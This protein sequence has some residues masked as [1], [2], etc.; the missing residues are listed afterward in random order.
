M[1]K[2]EAKVE[3][4]ED[5]GV[6]SYIYVQ[7]DGMKMKIIKSKLPQWLDVGDTIFCNFPE[8]SV[9]I[10]KDCTKQVSVENCLNASLINIRKS[11]PLC[12]L[13]FD[14]KMGKVV[15][16][17]TTDSFDLLDLKSGDNATMLIRG[18]DINI[19]PKIENHQ[20]KTYS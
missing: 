6:V 9:C 10:G 3:H 12:E 19:E 2:I 20:I 18:I 8:A 7:S 17:I 16:L 14:S 11:E 13:T 5:L 4:I 15:S 1:N